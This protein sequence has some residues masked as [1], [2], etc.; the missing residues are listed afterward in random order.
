MR[1][2]ERLG[3]WL[4]VL[5]I[6]SQT[7]AVAETPGRIEAAVRAYLVRVGL[8][9]ASGAPAASDLA[10]VLAEGNSA[11]GPILLGDGTAAAPSYSFED[12]PDTGMYRGLTGGNAI[13]FAL[14][15]ADF[16]EFWNNA[17]LKLINVSGDNGWQASGTIMLRFNQNGQVWL[18]NLAALLGHGSGSPEGA[19]A[20][21]VG[22]IYLRTGDG[23]AG[24]TLYVKESGTGNT[25][26]VAK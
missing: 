1:R 4:A 20:A 15:G 11:A 22:S 2:A 5:L 18:G 17:G 14:G 10:S 12:D 21:P 19:I 23:G 7:P 13:R 25:G 26:W 16:L 6:A 8:L 24:S 3:L 9:D